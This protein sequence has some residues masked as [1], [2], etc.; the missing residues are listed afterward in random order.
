MLL[1][2]SFDRFDLRVYQIHRID[3][4]AVTRQLIMD[5]PGLSASSGRFIERFD[6]HRIAIILP[7]CT[8]ELFG[9]E[10]GPPVDHVGA[11]VLAA[12]R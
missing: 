12:P 10:R 4:I 11:I 6:L 8:I 2:I 3:L 7:I 5:E 9:L 1:Q